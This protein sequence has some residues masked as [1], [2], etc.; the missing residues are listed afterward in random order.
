MTIP[1]RNGRPSILLPDPSGHAAELRALRQWVGWT[2]EPPPMGGAAAWAKVP[3][4]AE[5]GGRAPT[6]NPATWAT[7]ED[8]WA[9]YS[10]SQSAEAA[11]SGLGFVF[12]S[13]D[14]YLC[15]DLDGIDRDGVLSD[16]AA[17]IVTALNSYTQRSVGG[18]GVHVFVKAELPE[19]GRRRG[20]VEMHA[21][22]G[23]FAMT[24]CV[25]PGQATDINPRQGQ[26]EALHERLF[27]PRPNPIADAGNPTRFGS[28]SATH[29]EGS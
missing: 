5:T 28:S 12:T 8:G 2:S 11:L 14:P 23:Y 9:A 15:G 17:E 25:F 3:R 26:V 1:T 13:S 4:D 24:G 16:D 18:N 6:T 29:K 27:G 19:G 7:F 10:R 20:N 22:G 21:E